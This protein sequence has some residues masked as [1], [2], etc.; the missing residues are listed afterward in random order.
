[1]NV[2]L[3][4]LESEQMDCRRAGVIQ[5]TLCSRMFGYDGFDGVDGGFDGV[6]GGF[7]DFDGFNGDGGFDGVEGDSDGFVGLG[8]TNGEDGFGFA[9]LGG[10]DG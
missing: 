9:G 2:G 6:D 1:M 10:F 7:D 5:A 3:K 8:D 4:L